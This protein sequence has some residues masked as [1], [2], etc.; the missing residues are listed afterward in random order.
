M[1]RQV[2]AMPAIDSVVV[3]HT[4][5]GDPVR[6]PLW[7]SM[8]IAGQPNSGK[9]NTCMGL[10]KAY[11]EAGNACSQAIVMDINRTVGAASDPRFV[12]AY[13][14]ETQFPLLLSFCIDEIGRRAHWLSEHPELD[15][16]PISEEMPRW[17]IY[18][19]EFNSL[20]SSMG[21]VIQSKKLRDEIIGQ[22]AY[23]ERVGRKY[24]LIVALC[25]QSALQESMG[26]TA[27]R[28]LAATRLVH[29]LASADE[30][31]AASGAPDASELPSAGLLKG[32]FWCSSYLQAGNFIK[33]RSCSPDTI[34]FAASMKRDAVFKR[35]PDAL[36]ERGF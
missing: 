9:T 35:V 14:P 16:V 21:S 22:V 36:K 13:Q 6:V 29:K 25:C 15:R 18:I 24:G 7:D 20:V 30:I 33:A 17:L 23:I 4:A 12:T 31:K 10:L 27:F 11:S 34:D 32:E 1:K 8:L 5:G 26:S 28:S 19:E 3:G 2:I